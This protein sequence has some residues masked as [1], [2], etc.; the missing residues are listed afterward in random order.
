MYQ[1]LKFLEPLLEL[2]FAQAG[3]KFLR[4]LIPPFDWAST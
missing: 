4:E 2:H 1:S 3:T